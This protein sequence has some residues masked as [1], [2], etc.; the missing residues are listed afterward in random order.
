MALVA[1]IVAVGISGAATAA[2]ATQTD[3]TV[4]DFLAG[5]PDGTYIG[6]SDAGGVDG[7]VVLE[8]TLGEEF[9]GGPGLPT[10]WSFAGAWPG[11]SVP[12]VSGGALIADGGF[13][14]TGDVYGPGR[15]V[16]F[17]AS[18]SRSPFPARRVWDRLRHSGVLGHGEYWFERRSALRPDKK[19]WA[20]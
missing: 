2:A 3:T 15:S 16:E 10:G 12:V 8:P 4:D 1:M 14:G 5:A 20:R 19:W 17:V 13:A 6:D 7:E 11:G 18:Y 9:D